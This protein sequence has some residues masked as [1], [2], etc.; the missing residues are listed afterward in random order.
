MIVNVSYESTL[1]INIFA[2]KNIFQKKK[3]KK[4]F[5]SVHK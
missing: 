5:T 2:V 3:H 4:K 1:K